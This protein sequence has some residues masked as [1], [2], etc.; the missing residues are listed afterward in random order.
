M[1]WCLVRAFVPLD[2]IVF[3][4]A[5]GVQQKGYMHVFVCS[6]K[7]LTRLHKQVRRWEQE[8]RQTQ[9]WTLSKAKLPS[10]LG[11]IPLTHGNLKKSKRHLLVVGIKT[12]YPTLFN[13]LSVI[14]YTENGLITIVQ[15]EVFALKHQSDI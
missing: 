8:I 14:F 15:C 9:A 4:T 11:T 12:G 5:V 1:A 10:Q 2:R 6:E 3:F 7:T 13:G